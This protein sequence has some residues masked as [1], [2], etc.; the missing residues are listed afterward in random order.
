M[1]WTRPSASRTASSERATTAVPSSAVMI[2]RW[3]SRGCAASAPI[4]R[5]RSAG[6]RGHSFRPSSF[7]SASW[8]RTMSQGSSPSRSST[9]RI[10]PASGGSS[11]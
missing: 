6:S 3:I 7:A 11:R 9:A 1:S 8:V 10:S 2:G 4:Q 5:S